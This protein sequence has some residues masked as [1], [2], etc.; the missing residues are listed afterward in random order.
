MIFKFKKFSINDIVSVLSFTVLSLSFFF[1]FD[2]LPFLIIAV[3]FLALGISSAVHS[4]ET[5]A[6]R[7]GPS[8]GTL[9]LALSVTVIEVALIVSL[10][11]NG[12]EDASNIAR[13]TVFAAIMIVTNGILGVSIIL[14]GFRFKEL[15]YQSVGTNSLMGIIAVLACLTLVLPN[16]TTSSSGP[17]YDT[18]QL[19]FV[20]VA[21]LFLY[22][23]LVWAQ[24]KTHKSYFES[25]T[26]NELDVL[27]KQEKIPSRN[28]ALLSFITLVLSLVA[29]VGLAKLLSPTIESG[30]IYF[31]A[32][33]AVLGII[34]AL[35][36]LAPETLAAVNA[37]KINQL[38]TSLNLA[39]GSGAASIALTI[40]VVSVYSLMTAQ[41]LNL[42]LDSKSSIFLLLTF[43]V[44]AFT[45]ASDRTTTLSGVMHLTI[46]ASYIAMTLMP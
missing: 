5:I 33:K 26:Q 36:V 20:S 38:Q 34:I 25:H 3:L 6:N 28:R 21:S 14:G 46:L 31:G 8:L 24:T 40:P 41:E 39:L 29:V 13:D 4:A 17:T 42:G 30:V 44:G 35:L 23:A 22:G 7:V 45:F 12:S 43:V 11:G 2:S 27:E 9:I 19:I 18:G 1:P 16:F 37:A 15:A 32:P 10:M